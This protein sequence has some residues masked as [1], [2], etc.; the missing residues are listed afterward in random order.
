MREIR[1]WLGRVWGRKTWFA[2]LALYKLAEDRILYSLNS[3][4][5][6]I[7]GES[8]TQAIIAAIPTLTWI[9]IPLTIAGILI[10]VFRDR[11]I[12]DGRWA[13]LRPEWASRDQKG[14][15]DGIH[16]EA[17]AVEADFNRIL[18]KQVTIEDQTNIRARVDALD[19]L[20]A[21]Y[22]DLWLEPGA[23][24]SDRLRRR[25]TATRLARASGPAWASPL[26]DRIEYAVWWLYRNPPTGLHGGADDWGSWDGSGWGSWDG[27]RQ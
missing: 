12:N 16:H 11:R 2:L 23:Y 22:S 10:T 25:W 14:H 24:W 27:S 9:A 18:G 3:V 13:V 6:R 20:V 8:A 17:S 4:I 21:G 26:R 19:A 5:D 15:W 7:F 1:A